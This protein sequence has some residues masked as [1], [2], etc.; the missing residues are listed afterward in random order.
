MSCKIDYIRNLLE[1]GYMYCEVEKIDVV[2]VILKQ[3]NINYQVFYDIDI[4]KYYIKEVA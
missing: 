2:E 4:D 1:L 3:H